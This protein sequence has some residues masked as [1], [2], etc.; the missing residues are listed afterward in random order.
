[1]NATEIEL[2]EMLCP[3]CLERGVRTVTGFSRTQGSHEI[4]DAHQEELAIEQ[5]LARERGRDGG[6]NGDRGPA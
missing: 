2:F 5:A 3:W 6:R 4:C 1:M